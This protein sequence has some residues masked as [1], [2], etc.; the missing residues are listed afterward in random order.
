M[1][2]LSVCL[3]IVAVITTVI[4]VLRRRRRRAWAA[5]SPAASVKPPDP[6]G[7]H[8]RGVEVDEEAWAE[9]VRHL[10][11]EGIRDEPGD[12]RPAGGPR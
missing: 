10:K 1:L 11:K 12:G 6:A 9:I 5:D 2:T 3:L 7:S 8:D 4:I